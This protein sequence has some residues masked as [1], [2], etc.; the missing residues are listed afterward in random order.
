MIIG[1]IA[2]QGVVISDLTQEPISTIRLGGIG[3]R[4]QPGGRMMVTSSSPSPVLAERQ[5]SSGRSASL[6]KGGTMIDMRAERPF[7]RG[8][9]DA[10]TVG[11]VI[12]ASAL[13]H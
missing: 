6:P 11:Y 2:R 5:G 13:F 8:S 7:C 4:M 12:P 10:A 1:L 9:S 3:L